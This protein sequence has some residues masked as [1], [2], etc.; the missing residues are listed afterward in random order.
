MM[1]FLVV[2]IHKETGL[3]DSFFTIVLIEL[4]YASTSLI[5]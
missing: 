3:Q 1:G 5:H 4:M 2:N